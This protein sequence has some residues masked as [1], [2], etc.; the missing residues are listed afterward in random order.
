MWGKCSSCSAHCHSLSFSDMDDINPCTTGG[1]LTYQFTCWFMWWVVH[2]RTSKPF[3]DNNQK[4]SIFALVYYVSVLLF[5]GFHLQMYMI[6]K[7]EVSEKGETCLILHRRVKH[8]ICWLAS[9]SCICGNIGSAY[10]CC[11]R[12]NVLVKGTCFCA[13]CVDAWVQILKVVGTARLNFLLSLS[14][15]I[16]H[17]WVWYVIKLV[18]LL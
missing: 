7:L 8:F 1:T 2:Q 10:T 18:A 12:V 15:F 9:P 16:F 4:S 5:I 11:L 3:L 6:K 17:F 14:I 13:S